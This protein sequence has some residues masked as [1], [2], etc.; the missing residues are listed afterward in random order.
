[1]LEMQSFYLGNRVKLYGDSKNRKI[2]VESMCDLVK[3]ML[4]QRLS[5]FKFLSWG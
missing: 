3:G 5:V 2:K 4:S 1:M